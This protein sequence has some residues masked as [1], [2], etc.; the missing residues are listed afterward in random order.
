ML[1]F[2]Y[3]YVAICGCIHVHV[4]VH[5]CVEKYPYLK[6]LIILCIHCSIALSPWGKLQHI[7]ALLQ[8]TG[9]LKNHLVLLC[10]LLLVAY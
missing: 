4:G 8:Q 1:Q 2:E 9:Y 10:K 3:T 6:P 7:Q 5:T